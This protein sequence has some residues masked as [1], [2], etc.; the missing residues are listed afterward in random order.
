[1]LF[2]EIRFVLHF[3]WLLRN[4]WAVA[5]ALNLLMS[6]SVRCFVG[7]QIPLW[8]LRESF[9]VHNGWAPT[10]RSFW[11]AHYCKHFLTIGLSFFVHSTYLITVVPFSRL[12]FLYKQQTAL[13]MLVGE[14]TFVVSMCPNHCGLIAF[15]CH[16]KKKKTHQS[17][18]KADWLAGLTAEW[19][20]VSFFFFF[21]SICN[22]ARY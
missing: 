21:F 20:G 16:S 13:N 6:C 3:T 19:D 7:G 8:L 17:R 1:M 10:T 4:P 22:F 12:R 9:G 18:W 15:K 11:N 14:P 5:S 2:T